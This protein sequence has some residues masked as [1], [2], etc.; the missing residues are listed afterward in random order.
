MKF[1]N[2][3]ENTFPPKLDFMISNQSVTC[4]GVQKTYPRV[5]QSPRSHDNLK[6]G[7]LG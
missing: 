4:S 3:R 1:C 7:S 6:K 2:F 5:S